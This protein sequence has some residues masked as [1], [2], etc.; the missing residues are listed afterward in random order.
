MYGCLGECIIMRMYGSHVVARLLPSC[1]P[2]KNY[3]IDGPYR[4]ISSRVVHMYM[5]ISYT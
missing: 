5:N 2:S 3:I 4:A 1:D